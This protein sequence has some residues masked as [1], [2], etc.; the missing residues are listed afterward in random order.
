MV[1]NKCQITRVNIL[2]SSMEEIFVSY[3]FTFYRYNYDF[4]LVQHWRLYPVA[5]YHIVSGH[6]SHKGTDCTS[7]QT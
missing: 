2:I 6:W 5:V 1:D 4:F 7:I 3:F